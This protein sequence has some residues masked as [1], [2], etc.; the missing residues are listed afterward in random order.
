MS[1]ERDWMEQEGEEG[2]GEND[3]AELNLTGDRK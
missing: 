2:G 1:S 3:E